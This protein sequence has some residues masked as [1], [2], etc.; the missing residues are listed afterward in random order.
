M[1]EKTIDDKTIDIVVSELLWRANQLHHIYLDES[2]SDMMR[3][4]AYHLYQGYK[5]A[6]FFVVNLKEA[7]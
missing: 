7:H 4:G 3:D 2:E 6:A 5:D 1:N